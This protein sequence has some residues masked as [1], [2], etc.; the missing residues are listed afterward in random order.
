VKSNRM[1]SEIVS[2]ESLHGV[3]QADIPELFQAAISEGWVVDETGA[4][5]LELFRRG[6]FGGRD[7]FTDLT[8]YEAAVNGRGVPDSDISE[9]GIARV[10]VLARRAYAFAWMALY[11]LR[12]IP[13]HA[14]VD[15]YISVGPT[16]MDNNLYTAS[17]TFCAIH[18]G[19]HPYIPDIEKAS[20]NAVLTLSSTESDTPLPV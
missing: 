17:V 1:F 5:L 2:P 10:Q 19:E 12:E 7:S 11:A 15:A 3:T 20:M 14:E 6:Y 9:E 8:G 4:Y 18:D 13:D 16:L